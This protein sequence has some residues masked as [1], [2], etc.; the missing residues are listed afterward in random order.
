MTRPSCGAE[1]Q[2][3]EAATL[4]AASKTHSGML[5]QSRTLEAPAADNLRGVDETSRPPTLVVGPHLCPACGSESASAK[6]G[7][8]PCNAELSC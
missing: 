4:P 7:V 8:R 3:N 1:G 5:P 2:R 6:A